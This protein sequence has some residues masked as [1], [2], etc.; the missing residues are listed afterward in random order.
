VF[1]N[2]PYNSPHE[3]AAQRKADDYAR[4]VQNKRHTLHGSTHLPDI[5]L[6]PLGKDRGGPGKLEACLCDDFSARG[7]KIPAE[8]ASHRESFSSQSH[9]RPSRLRVAIAALKGD[10]SIAELAKRFDVHPNSIV[11]WKTQLVERA[12]DAIGADAAKPAGPDVKD[13]HAKIG[14][15]TLEKRFFRTRTRTYRRVERKV[16]IAR[17]HALPIRDQ[18]RLIDL[19]SSTFY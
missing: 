9:T 16:M 4:K 2:R 15:L 8:G 5:L 3:H 1:L 17:E 14:Q 10:Q 13:L 18:L 19:A 7:R 6:H 11:Q 12:G